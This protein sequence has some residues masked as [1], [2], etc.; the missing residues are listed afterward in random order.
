MVSAWHMFIL[1]MC[2]GKFPVR[3]NLRHEVCKNQTCE[4]QVCIW[5]GEELEVIPSTL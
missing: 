3:F 1:Q 2:E 5:N 4:G